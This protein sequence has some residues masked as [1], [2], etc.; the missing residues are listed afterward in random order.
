MLP[1]KRA[2]ILTAVREWTE[3]QIARSGGGYSGSRMLLPQLELGYSTL[4]LLSDG[5][6]PV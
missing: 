6:I 1:G 2:A 3:M 4:V 5:A